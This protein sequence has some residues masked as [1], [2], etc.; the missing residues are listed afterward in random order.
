MSLNAHFPYA[1]TCPFF[2]FINLHK[3][4]LSV[5]YFHIYISESATVP[6]ACVCACMPAYVPVTKNMCH[7]V[8]VC[9]CHVCLLAVHAY[10]CQCYSAVKY[11]E[12]PL[13]VEDQGLSYY[14]FYI[15][16]FFYLSHHFL[17]HSCLFFS[18]GDSTAKFKTTSCF[19]KLS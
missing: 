13:N 16:L 9:Q 7:F 17:K 3:V 12:F 6:G 5:T 1:I 10:M 15:F 19:S 14:R 4:S 18:K 2:K 11:S 8:C